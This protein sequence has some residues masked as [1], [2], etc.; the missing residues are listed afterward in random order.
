MHKENLLTFLE[1]VKNDLLQVFDNVE[2]GLFWGGRLEYTFSS[3]SGSIKKFDV[4]IDIIDNNLANELVTRD[5]VKQYIIE[6][7]MMAVYEREGEEPNG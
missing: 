6:L 4:D 5:Q 1:E 7:A 2:Y 3:K